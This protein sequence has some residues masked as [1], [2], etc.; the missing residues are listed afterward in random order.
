MAASVGPSARK[1]KKL[2]PEGEL[3][4]VRLPGKLKGSVI[5]GAG[6]GSVLGA[7]IQRK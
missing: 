4:A 7:Q 2:L 5:W 1:L 6:S 3:Y